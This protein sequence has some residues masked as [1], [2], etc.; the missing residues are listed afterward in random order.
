M[1]TFIVLSLMVSSASFAQ[2]LTLTSLKSFM[3]QKQTVIERVN[4]GMTK[5]LVTTGKIAVDAAVC[6]YTTT[7]D[8]SV[9]KI[10]GDKIIIHSK[11]KFSPDASTACTTAQYTPYEESIIFYSDKPSLTL[12]VLDL[13]AIAA[14]VQTISRVGDL[15]T[16]V[17]KSTFEE[18]DGTQTQDLVT[19]KYDFTKSSFKNLVQTQGSD[20]QTLSIDK[21][22]INV[23]LV[24]L[25]NI[26]FCDNN[27]GD[28]SECS[29]GDFTDILY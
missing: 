9:L 4:V 2:S 18:D 19:Y 28:N 24:N 29:Q 5:Q 14:D 15:V 16:M 8:Q 27:D 25:S 22:D 6:N 1:K 21:T 7:T 17:I 3:G 10:E 20:F 13:D 11:E 23:N 12:D 26:L